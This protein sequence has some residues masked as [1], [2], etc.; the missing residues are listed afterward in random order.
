LI[1]ILFYLLF[2]MVSQ[3]AIAGFMEFLSGFGALSP[4][5]VLEFRELLSVRSLGSGEVL[6]ERGRRQHSV[7]F[8]FA[9]VGR[10]VVIVEGADRTGWFWFSPSLVFAYPGFFSMEAAP[11]QIV[12]LCDG[13]VVELDLSQ[14]VD[15]LARH[16]EL[17]LVVERLRASHERERMAH[18]LMLTTVPARERY[19]VFFAAHPWL[20]NLARHRDIA[21]FLGIR[22]DGFHRYR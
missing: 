13:I 5:L 16:G 9:G 11:A 15:L 22:D 10:E 7:C 8:L 14:W 21:S 18:G 17:G 1:V 6:V 3:V 19:R 4:G 12:M 20:F 2:L